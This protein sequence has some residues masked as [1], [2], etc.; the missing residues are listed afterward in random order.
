MNLL[1]MFA[2]KE[3]IK[4]SAAN[5]RLL[6]HGCT[7]EF[8]RDTCHGACCETRTPG[9][10]HGILIVVYRNEAEALKARGA[11]VL[12]DGDTRIMETGGKKTNC[13][14]KKDHL[15]GLHFEREEGEKVK[16]WTCR[17]APWHLNKYGTL[18]IRNHYK[19]FSC[20]GSGIPAYLAFREGLEMIFGMEA[21]AGM[22]KHFE[23]GGG[24]VMGTPLD[25]VL[26][27]IKARDS[28]VTAADGK[29]EEDRQRR[30]ESD[31]KRFRSVK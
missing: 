28:V 16:P 10:N 9:T 17:A 26:E 24:D 23:A 21:A 27:R 13:Q 18:I 14:F 19:M 4:V 7:P 11:N 6:F 15:C 30:R 20:Y 29:T 8:I 25:G 31:R 5:A 1:N 22:I 2:V 3:Q 12:G